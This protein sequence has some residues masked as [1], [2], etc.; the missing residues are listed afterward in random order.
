[1]RIALGEWLPDQAALNNVGATTALNVFPID[2]G[3]RSI[4]GLTPFTDA[5]DNRARGGYS[6]SS[7][8]GQTHSFAADAGKLYKLGVS[9]F[10]D[11]SKTGGYST[12]QEEVWN[13]AQFG[14]Y[15]VAANYNDSLQS[16]QMG[17]SSNFA[18]LGG[19]PPSDIRYLAAIDP[20]FLV[21]ADEQTIHWSGL[22]DITTWQASA[23]TQAGSQ[24][25]PDGGRIMGIVGGEYGVIIQQN[26]IRVMRYVGTPLIFEFVKIENIR[27]T[28][29]PGS[30]V[31]LGKRVFYKAEDGFYM[32]DGNQ[33]YPIG[34]NKI[35]KDF[36]EK[37][38]STYWYRVSAAVDPINK[39]VIWSYPSQNAIDGQP[40]KLL[41]YNYTL[42]K[43]SEAEVDVQFIYRGMH[44][45]Y[46]LEDLDGI[47]T[48]IDSI[49][50]SLDSNTWKGGSFLFSA[51]NTDNKLC[52]FSGNDLV[53]QVETGEFELTPGFRTSLQAVRPLIDCAGSISVEVGGRNLQSEEHAYKAPANVRSTG[54]AKTR[55]NK[56]YHRVKLTITDGFKFALGMD[57]EGYKVGKR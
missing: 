51:F 35:D 26:A 48:D 9:G 43:W 16:Y 52:S 3:Y 15:I 49:T 41:I 53:A 1:M 30:V 5:L 33:S 22:E 24:T 45:G 50:E 42:N 54:V 47:S 2:R 56:R 25:L 20:G 13:F 8:I 28:V 6:A 39:L 29:I 12:G 40:D 21:A 23:T 34:D 19:N 11:I 17:V 4:N 27:G 18:D 36:L 7:S 32:F 57:V 55:S 10:S 37:Y 38:D 44:I 46:T 14:D 31:A